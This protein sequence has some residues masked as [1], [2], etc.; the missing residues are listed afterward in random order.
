MVDV[1]VVLLRRRWYDGS[2]VRLAVG[3]GLGGGGVVRGE[4]AGDD[5]SRRVC[6]GQELREEL[7]FWIWDF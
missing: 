7:G 4:I 2:G 6:H 5:G 1:C 3:G